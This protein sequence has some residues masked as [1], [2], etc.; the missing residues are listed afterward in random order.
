MKD[1]VCGMEVDEKS[2]FKSSHNGKTYV[3]CSVG[4]KQA[5]D[6]KPENYT[7]NRQ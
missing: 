6:K 2:A 3:F 1:F 4:C 7:K 5:F